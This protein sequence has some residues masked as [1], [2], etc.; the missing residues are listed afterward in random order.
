LR[1][2]LVFACAFGG[3]LLSLF[4]H[5][6]VP[7]RHLSPESKDVGRLGMGLSA[8]TVALVIGLLVASGK[9]FYDTQTNEVT[10]SHLRISATGWSLVAG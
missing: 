1:P 6:L 4:I 3:A 5:R 10:H 2:H 9:S 8:T 7:D